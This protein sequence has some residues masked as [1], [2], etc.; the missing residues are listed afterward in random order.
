MREPV[1]LPTSGNVCDLNSMKRILLNDEHDPFNRAPLKLSDL[2]EIPDLKA[3]IDHWIAQKKAGIS[4]TDEDLRKLN[5][6]KEMKSP[7]D[8]ND[9]YSPELFD[10][11]DGGGTGLQMTMSQM[12]K[13]NMMS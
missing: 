4:P 10:G 1:L 6:D 3:R 11:M 13:D 2:K 12:N 5:G 7:V 8:N 9:D